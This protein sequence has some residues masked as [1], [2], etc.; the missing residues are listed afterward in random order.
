ME[1]YY[2]GKAVNGIEVDSKY[3]VNGFY[4]S[5]GY[6]KISDTFLEAGVLHVKM[7]KNL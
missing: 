4:E 5:C 1:D 7:T 3:E 2:R 6:K